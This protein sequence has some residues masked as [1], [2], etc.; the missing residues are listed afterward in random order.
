[1]PEKLEKHFRFHTQIGR[2][3]RRAWS[4]SSQIFP[5]VFP[6]FIYHL[7]FGSFKISLEQWGEE[8]SV[9]VVCGCVVCLPHTTGRLR[10]RRV[11]RK[12]S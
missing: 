7:Q 2:A 3:L 1:M 5:H 10:I 11:Q 6:M 4:W 9:G 8:L 12:Y